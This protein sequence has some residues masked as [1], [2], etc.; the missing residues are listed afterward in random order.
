MELLIK[1]WLLSSFGNKVL[2]LLEVFRNR[3]FHLEA[4]RIM[5][6]EGMVMDFNGALDFVFAGR[7]AVRYL[8]LERSAWKRERSS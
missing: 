7:R 5:D 4:L 6:A 8:G 2:H 3:C 1:N